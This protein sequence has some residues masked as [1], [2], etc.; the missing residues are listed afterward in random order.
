MGKDKLSGRR[1]VITGASSGIGLA[2]VPR[3]AAAGARLALIA[4]DEERLAEAVDA[5]GPA[6]R[7]FSADLGEG[8]SA[9]A[10]IAAA[11][12]WLGGIDVLV[13]NAAESSYGPF[14]DTPAEDFERTIEST[15]GTG[16]NA[17]R[18]ALPHLDESEGSVVANLSVL[19]RFPVPMFS[20]Y[21]AAKHALRG[22][23]GALR[24]ELERDGSGVQVSIV[25]PGHVDTP[26]WG[27]VNSVTGRLPRLPPLAYDADR[28]AAALV[29]AAERPRREHTVGALARL[30]VVVAAVA[31]PLVDLS[32]RA[33]GR[34]LESGEQ[35]AA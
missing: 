26:F 5:A 28:V 4:R 23:L 8:D 10:A 6:A 22:F 12:R 31:M 27:R 33:L 2:A 30:Q 17:V 32:G 11:A 20:G 19:S 7:A 34:W 15:F 3:F 35:A 21:V 24:I 13:L 29:D 9:D 16:V 18:A 14:R 25:H 1:V